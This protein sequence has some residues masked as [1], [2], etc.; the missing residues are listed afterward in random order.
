[1][2]HLVGKDAVRRYGEKLDRMSMRAPWSETL[3]EILSRLLTPDEVQ[4]LLVMPW[5]LSSVE[6]IARTAGMPAAAVLAALERLADKGL[7]ID[8]LVGETMHYTPSPMVVGIFEFSMMRRDAAADSATMA[9]LFA[10]Y[11]GEGDF[12]AANFGH[13]ERVS[14]LRAL[15][16]QEALGDHVEV[17]D[18][19]KASAIVAGSDRFALGVCAC[20]HE[21]MHTTGRECTGPLE[22]CTSI[23]V[24]ADLA[25][26][27]GFCREASRS[28][29]VD[30]LARSRDEGLVLCADNTQRHVSFIC[31]CCSCCC[32]VLRAINDHGYSNALVTSSFIARSEHERCN[33]CGKCATACPIDAIS[34]EI[35]EHEPRT[36]TGKA[37]SIDES[38]CLG[39]GVCGVKC[40]TGAMRLQPRPHRVLHPETAFER[41]VLQCLER[42][43]LQYQLFDDPTSTSQA[44]LRGLLGAFLGLAPVKQALMS[45]TLRSR[46]LAALTSSAAR[47]GKGELTEL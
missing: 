13:G 40:P 1:M 42:G 29:M 47:Q 20:R 45:D 31:H 11:L 23:G 36:R 2:G 37:P 5:G 21:R 19:E 46:F 10:E 17:L 15:P 33:G 44:M 30:N 34:M 35:D 18:Y 3:G 24:A 4:L 32:H 28:E 25:I 7:V 8:I 27:H 6:R 16:H 12:F 41:I 9:R 39:C 43:T 26:R 22:V 14:V 38:T